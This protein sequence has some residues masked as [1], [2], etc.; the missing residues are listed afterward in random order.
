MNTHTIPF[1]DVAKQDLGIIYRLMTLYHTDSTQFRSQVMNMLDGPPEAT[2]KTS[3]SSATSISGEDARSSSLY[4]TIVNKCSCGSCFRKFARPDRVPWR[5]LSGNT[6]V[7][8]AHGTVEITESCPVSQ[9]DAHGYI[10]TSKAALTANNE[11]LAENF[12]EQQQRAK[13]E[14]TQLESARIV[15]DQQ[16]KNSNIKLE[17]ERHDSKQKAKLKALE[18]D[19]T[20][21]MIKK[22]G[23]IMQKIE[24]LKSKRNQYSGNPNNRSSYEAYHQQF[25]SARNELGNIAYSKEIEL[26]TLKEELRHQPA[27]R[28]EGSVVSSERSSHTQG[29]PRGALSSS[30]TKSLL[31][32]PSNNTKEGTTL[33]ADRVYMYVNAKSKH[34]QGIVDAEL[35]EYADNI[36]DAECEALMKKLPFQRNESENRYVGY[37]ITHGMT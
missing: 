18:A 22:R 31:P 4:A 21:E 13:L 25:L 7:N 24:S 32:T 1:V 14:H 10:Y 8:A 2:S 27:S 28:N 23:E 29:Q 17:R 11:V 36:S 30:T 35:I 34:L 3:T 33:A 12:K 5:K 26:T 19:K 20:R 15:A 6:F 37:I 16:R 9:S